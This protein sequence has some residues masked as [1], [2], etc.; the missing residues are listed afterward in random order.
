VNK[1]TAKQMEKL[2]KELH[3]RKEEIHDIN[4]LVNKDIDGKLH[5][6]LEDYSERELE[7]RLGEYH[8]LLAKSANP[9]PED[10]VITTP[11]KIL[12]KPVIWI[13]RRLLNVV[14][15]HVTSV[16]EKQ[17]EFNQKCLDLFQ[18]LIVHQK[19]MSRKINHLEQRINE[20]EAQLDI[21]SKRHEEM[22]SKF[23]QNE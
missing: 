13:K 3:E 2:K 17:R 9:L 19:K 14:N 16:M 20:C 5:S 21:I 8:A 10:I 1:N 22:A 18:T 7:S 15:A 6:R 11:R 12:K 4:Q 23:R